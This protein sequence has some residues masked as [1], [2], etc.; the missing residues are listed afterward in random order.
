MAKTSLKNSPANTNGELPEKGS[1]APDFE[2]LKKDLS[3]VHLKD[4][5][6]KKILNIFPSLDTGTCAASVKR[7][8][9]EAKKFRDVT[10]LNI[11]KDLPFAQGRFCE[12]F[13]I[14]DSIPLSAFRSSFARDYGVELVDSPLQG[15]CARAVVLLDEEN[16]VLYWELV[17]EI[18]EEPNYEKVLAL[19]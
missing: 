10:I 1:V 19:I 15:L 7:F 14:E 12:A 13:S 6:G 18:I 3:M 16:V 11:S 2:L 4:F 9:D 17:R 5:S 8:N